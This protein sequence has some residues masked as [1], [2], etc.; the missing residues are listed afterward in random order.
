MFIF[1]R[2]CSITYLSRTNGGKQGT[3]SIVGFKL[4]IFKKKFIFFTEINMSYGFENYDV[5]YNFYIYLKYIINVL[6]FFYAI[7]K[8]ANIKKL[9][10]DIDHANSVSH[11]CFH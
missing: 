1:K 5:K 7:N 9:I 4:K 8:I 2:K 3:Y 10:Y 6:R 11:Y